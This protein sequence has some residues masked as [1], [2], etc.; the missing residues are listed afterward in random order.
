VSAR[1]APGRAAVVFLLAGALAGAGAACSASAPATRALPPRTP[2]TAADLATPAPCVPAPPASPL[3]ALE[4]RQAE[5]RGCTSDVALRP[6]AYDGYE[7]AF[8][9]ARYES[10]AAI[11]IRRLGDTRRQPFV[12]PLSRTED[13][14]MLRLSETSRQIAAAASVHGS[15]AVQ[16]CDGKALALSIELGDYREVDGVV[17]RLGAWLAR[18]VL[19][20]EAIVIVEPPPRAVHLAA[21]RRAIR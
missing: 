16:S 19:N 13:A 18:E 10:Q 15:R 12:P 14:A 11:V 4:P 17:R 8:G 3:H 20:V 1:R 5:T 6:G 9:C 21:E 2:V 7:V